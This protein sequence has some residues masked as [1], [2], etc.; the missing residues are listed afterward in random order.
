MVNKNKTRYG[1]FYK[2]RGK[3][4]TAPYLGSTLTKKQVEL[5]MI[6]RHIAFLKKYVLKSKVKIRRVNA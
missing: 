3:W 4:T 2:I 6:K 5:P 1:L